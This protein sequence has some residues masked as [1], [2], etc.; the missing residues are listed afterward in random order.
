M[1]NK[2]VFFFYFE[3]RYKVQKEMQQLK[4]N[5]LFVS[6]VNSWG[7]FCP[8]WSPDSYKLSSVVKEKYGLLRISHLVKNEVK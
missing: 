1:E 5:Y 2:I 3:K 8:I 7:P 6:F 4:E